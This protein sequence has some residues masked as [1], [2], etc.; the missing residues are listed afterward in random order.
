M[1]KVAPVTLPE[2]FVEFYEDVESWQNELFFRLKKKHAVGEKMDAVPLVQEEGRPLIELL[3]FEISIEDYR[4]AFLAFAELVKAKREKSTAFVDKILELRDQLDYGEMLNRLLEDDRLYFARLEKETGV[5]MN[6]LMLIAQHSLRPFL[7]VFALPY[8]ESFRK[9]ENLGWGKGICPVCGAVPSISRVRS[10]D[11]RRFLFCEECFTEWEHRYLSCIYCGN[12]EPSTIKYFV[13][14]GDD[15]NQ[16]FVCEKCKGY[17]KN[18]DERKGRA[19][20]DMFITNIKTI[21]LDLLAEQKGYGHRD[22]SFN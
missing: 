21:Y 5:P 3:D 15:A 2:G 1:S 19:R 13:V 20:N 10:H 22:N 8:E 7:R 11:G 6:V 12:D 18:Y 16:V 9:D 4:E 14:D 17:L